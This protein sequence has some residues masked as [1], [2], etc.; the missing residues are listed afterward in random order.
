MNIRLSDILKDSNYSLSQF[1]TEK[2]SSLEERLKIKDLKGKATPYIYCLVR[3]KDIKLTPE[4]VVRQLYLQTLRDDY[5]YPVSRMELEYIV[6]FGRE[7]KRADIVIFDKDQTT[8]P[9]IIVELK[10][11]KL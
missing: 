4:E 8:T 6:T 11:P 7:K 2:I 3:K 1:D 9:Y 5:G 10:S